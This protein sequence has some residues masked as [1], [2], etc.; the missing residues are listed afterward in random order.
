[1]N[2]CRKAL[3][4]TTLLSSHLR[5]K[6]SS[7]NGQVLNSSPLQTMLPHITVGVTGRLQPRK[8][9][10]PYVQSRDQDKQI[11]CNSCKAKPHQAYQFQIQ[12]GIQKVAKIP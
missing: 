7:K 12:E 6:L 11:C 4:L 5:S 2:F 10:A 8:A 1:M 3:L 9:A